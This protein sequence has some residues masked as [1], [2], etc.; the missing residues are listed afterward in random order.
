MSVER[1]G[2]QSKEAGEGVGT[3]DTCR[4]HIRFTP[5][6]Y[7][8]LKREQ[9][10]TGRSIPWLLKTRYFSAVEL[11]PPAFDYK[12]SCEILRQLGGIGNNMNQIAKRVNSS[13]AD[14]VLEHI[15]EMRKLMKDIHTLAMR[16]YG[17]R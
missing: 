4:T 13:I 15:A 6:E 5:A 11:R 16:D 8:R 10:L 14:A 2:L 12:T 1:E 3:T 7:R 9:L 17:D